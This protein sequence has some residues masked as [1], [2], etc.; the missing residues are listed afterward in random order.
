[1]LVFPARPVLQVP[2]LDQKIYTCP[3][4]IQYMAYSNLESGLQLCRL[5]K[6]VT[7]SRDTTHTQAIPF[8][9]PRL[10]IQIMRVEDDRLS[11][12]TSNLGGFQEPSRPSYPGTGM[13]GIHPAVCA[14][15]SMCSMSHVVYQNWAS[16]TPA[17]KPLP[18]PATSSW[19]LGASSW[20]NGFVWKWGILK[21][22][23]FSIGN[24]WKNNDNHWILRLP[25]FQTNPHSISSCKSEIIWNHVASKTWLIP[26][27]LPYS[28][29]LALRSFDWQWPRHAN[30]SF[31]GDTP[32][33]TAEVRMT[34]RYSGDWSSP[35]DACN[36]LQNHPPGSN[37]CNCCHPS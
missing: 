11:F 3:S 12:L 23:Q 25:D 15:C 7:I 27:H 10:A 34:R 8:E 22:S 26:S 2:V 18:S 24:I 13:D 20:T 5:L 14:V 19:L 16:E 35:P 1:M 37:K 9:L 17:Q 4:C 6:D 28:M 21:S 30:P 33:A 32:V 36:T 29:F 31:D